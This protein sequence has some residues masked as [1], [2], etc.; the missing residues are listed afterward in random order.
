MEKNIVCYKSRT[1]MKVE[2]IDDISRKVAMALQKRIFN[3]TLFKLREQKV[4]SDL[5]TQ[6]IIFYIKFLQLFIDFVT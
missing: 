6:K 5:R 2:I 4:R 1:Y 3:D